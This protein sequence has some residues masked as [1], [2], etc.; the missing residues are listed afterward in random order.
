VEQKTSGLIGIIIGSIWLLINF[1]HVTEQGFVAIGMP[2][3]IIVLGVVYFL[4]G[5]TESK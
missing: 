3:V 2:L 1:R 4:K 5:S